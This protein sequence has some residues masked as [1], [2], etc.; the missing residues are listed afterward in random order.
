MI[1]FL[2]TKLLEFL[3]KLCELFGSETT[4]VDEAPP[5]EPAKPAPDAVPE[6]T[7][8]PEA[9]PEEAPKTE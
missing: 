2:R 7:P 3:A 1:A 9:K 6:A 4:S 8:A 5:S